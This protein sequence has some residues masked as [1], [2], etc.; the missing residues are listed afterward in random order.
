MTARVDLM[1]EQGLVEEVRALKEMGCTG[2]MASM[3]GLGYKEISGLP[4]RAA[5]L[6]MRQFIY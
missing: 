5:A 1:M 6:W 3:Q 4:E 2:S